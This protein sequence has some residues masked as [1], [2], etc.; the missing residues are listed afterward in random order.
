MREVRAGERERPS[1]DGVQTE[2]PAGS[3]VRFPSSPRDAQTINPLDLPA[4]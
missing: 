4:L 3:L 2:T 1:D